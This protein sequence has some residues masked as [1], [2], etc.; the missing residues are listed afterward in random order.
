MASIPPLKRLSPEQFKDQSS[1][2]QP[3]LT[4]INDFMERVVSALNKQLTVNENT[5]GAIKDVTLDGTFPV[6]LAWD[7]PRPSV[8]LVGDVQGLDS[9]FSL[10]TAVQVQWSFNQS[11]QLQIDAVVGI[12]PTA[13]DRYSVTL[14]A[15]S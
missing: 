12:S 8:V 14:L 5:T 11:G 6:K 7:K 15:L 3:L 13:T 9:T 2:I 1:W 4:S 10:S